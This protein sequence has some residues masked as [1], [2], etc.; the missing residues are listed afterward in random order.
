MPFDTVKTGTRMDDRDT[1]CKDRKPQRLSDPKPG[2][3]E[4]P[5]DCQEIELLRVTY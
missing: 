4:D 5:G 2:Q 1:I 3:L